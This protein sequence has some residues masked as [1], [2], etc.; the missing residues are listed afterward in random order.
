MSDKLQVQ[1][2]QN[3][4]YPCGI[5]L[6]DCPQNLMPLYQTLTGNLELVGVDTANDLMNKRVARLVQSYELS[7]SGQENCLDIIQCKIL[8]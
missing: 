1:L 3:D 6:E 5:V 7:N 8:L 4:L 2:L